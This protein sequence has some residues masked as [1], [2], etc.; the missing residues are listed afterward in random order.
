MPTIFMLIM[1]IAFAVF[2]CYQLVFLMMME[3]SL[4]PG[5]QDKLIWG[6]L[7]ALVAGLAPFAFL[8]WRKAMLSSG[9]DVRHK[10]A[11]P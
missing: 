9:N 11:Q 4:F 7:F 8:F 5:K 6:V 10:G 1:A 2:W 3:D